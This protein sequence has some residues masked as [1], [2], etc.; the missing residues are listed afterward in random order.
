MNVFFAPFPDDFTDRQMDI[1]VHSYDTWNLDHTLGVIIE[2]A[3]RKFIAEPHGAP[4]V[5]NEDVVQNLH[6]PEGMEDWVCDEFWYERWEYVLGEML[7]AFEYG[8]QD[9]S[10]DT[11]TDVIGANEKR[12]NE[13]R[14]LFAKYFHHLWN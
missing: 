7:Y 12:A 2:A 1:T 6:R 8:N 3:L 11:P 10:Y 14:R 13:G 9:N 4:F 5:Y